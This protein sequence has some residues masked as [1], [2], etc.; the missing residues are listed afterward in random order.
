MT[1]RN[2]QPRGNNTHRRDRRTI[3]ESTFDMN[4]WRRRTPNLQPFP[5]IQR[6]TTDHTEANT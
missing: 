6:E 1:G 3:W 5:P 2:P 4:L